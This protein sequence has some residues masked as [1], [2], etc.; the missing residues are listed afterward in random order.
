[1]SSSACPEDHTSSPFLNLR[2]AYFS[3]FGSRAH[4]YLHL[5][6]KLGQLRLY[7]IDVALFENLFDELSARLSAKSVNAVLTTAAA[8]FKLSIRRKLANGKP[9]R[10]RRAR[11]HGRN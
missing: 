6:P 9:R 8:I 3:S 11:L 5:N 4:I 7:R 1:M 10:G 2:P